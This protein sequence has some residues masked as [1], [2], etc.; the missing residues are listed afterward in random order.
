MAATFVN[1]HLKFNIWQGDFI[2]TT[3]ASRLGCVLFSCSMIDLLLS[4]CLHTLKLSCLCFT[5]ILFFAAS[6]SS[7][8]FS[9]RC[10]WTAASHLC[11]SL[12]H[13]PCL[14][15]LSHKYFLLRAGIS[16]SHC[17]SSPLLCFNIRM[18]ACERNSIII[19]SCQL[20][21]QQFAKE[22]HLRMVL[23]ICLLKK[24]VNWFLMVCTNPTI[25]LLRVCSR[26][27]WR[28]GCRRVIAVAYSGCCLLGGNS[29][30]CE[31]SV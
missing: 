27:S 29:G 22:L 20:H 16:S 21:Y 2:S 18:V 6:S 12:S 23:K 15:A 1:F 7:S 19:L 17:C 4:F 5:H 24:F 8:C 9:S 11:F 30:I 25:N 31:L 26:I 3:L 13:L 28:Y 14:F 10:F